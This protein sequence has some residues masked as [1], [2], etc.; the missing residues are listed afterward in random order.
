MIKNKPL[1]PAS[2]DSKPL[3]QSRRRELF[4]ELLRHA[5]SFGAPFIPIELS[6]D[7]LLT[8]V[9]RVRQDKWPN[10][11]EKITGPNQT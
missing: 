11:T 1:G 9:A 5:A 8:A 3:S 2:V 4:G 6:G 7:Q 10:W